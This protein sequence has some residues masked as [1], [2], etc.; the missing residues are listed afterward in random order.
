MDENGAEKGREEAQRRRWRRR[1][2]ERREGE[3][4]EKGEMRGEMGD[5]RRQAVPLLCF[6]AFSAVFFY[7]PCFSLLSV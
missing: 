3:R 4:G 2:W 6:I 5:K 1:R 7:I